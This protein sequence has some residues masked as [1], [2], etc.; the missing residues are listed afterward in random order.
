MRKCNVNVSK[1]RTDIDDQYGEWS[2]V[3]EENERQHEDY[4][5][6]IK[7]DKKDQLQARIMTQLHKECPEHSLKVRRYFQSFEKDHG[8]NCQ[9]KGQ[10]KIEYLKQ[11]NNE[12]LQG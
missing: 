12:W 5:S 7:H 2:V 11:V 9:S 6:E 3:C 1:N 4:S 8:V 10:S